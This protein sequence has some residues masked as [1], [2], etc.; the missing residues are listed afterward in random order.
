MLGVVREIVLHRLA[1]RHVMRE[2]DEKLRVRLAG[3]EVIR[4]VARD[5]LGA[6]P[7]QQH[8]KRGDEDSS[9]VKT[10]G[11]QSRASSA[12]HSLRSAGWGLEISRRTVARLPS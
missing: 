7:S 9:G 12:K 4:L 8:A 6:R 2:I 3:A 5:A 10:R 11:L 1:Q